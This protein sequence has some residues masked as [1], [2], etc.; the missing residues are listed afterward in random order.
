MAAC[1]G[2]E[3]H[4]AP[5]TL[6]RSLAQALAARTEAVTAA[7]AAGDS[8]RASALAHRLQQDTIASINSGRV[9]AAL[10]EP[11]SGT[12]NDLVGRI[13]CVPPPP[14]REEH[15]RGK[16]KGHAKKDKAGD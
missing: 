16:H 10:Q 2:G 6:P 5:P 3:R 12:V 4:A 8:C 15:G 13:V 14:P 7:L 11:L 9:A 1:G